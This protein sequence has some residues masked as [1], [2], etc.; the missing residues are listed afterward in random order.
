MTRRYPRETDMT[1]DSQLKPWGAG[2]G[3]G[4]LAFGVGDAAWIGLVAKDLYDSEMPHLM[5][6]VLNPA[7]AAGFYALYVAAATHLAT[8]PGEQRTLLQ[9]A[10]DGAVL[11]AAAYGAWGL[12][13][14][15]VLKKFPVSVALT[16]MAW[17]AFATA[18]IATV[19]GI[20]ADRVRR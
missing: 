3:A 20:A 17:G 2:F 11:G 14:A 4:A 1:K 19:G 10:R 13:G 9:R 18:L 7:P 15:S 5:A 12:T 16:D 8:R 6:D